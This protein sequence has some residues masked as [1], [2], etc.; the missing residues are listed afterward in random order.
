[1]GRGEEG[2]GAR[3]GCTFNGGEKIIARP[4]SGRA[5]EPCDAHKKQH[6]KQYTQDGAPSNEQQAA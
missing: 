4:E 1:M 5:A 3:E 6:K 2:E